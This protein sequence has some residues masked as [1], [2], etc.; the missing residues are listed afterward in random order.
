MPYTEVPAFIADLRRREAV[1]ALALEF[2]IL[3]ASRSGEVLGAKWAEIDQKAKVWTV[4]PERMK[5]G[6]EHRVPLRRGLCKSW[7]RSR[8]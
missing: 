2:C 6:R 5:G 8:R 1:A 3:N 7:N 4:P